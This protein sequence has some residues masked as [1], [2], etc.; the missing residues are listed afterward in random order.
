[1]LLGV[2]RAAFERDGYIHVE[3]LKGQIVEVGSTDESKRAEQWIQEGLRAMESYVQKCNS[4][5]PTANEDRSE[6]L[7]YILVKNGQLFAKWKYSPLFK[8]FVLSSNRGNTCSYTII[9]HHLMSVNYTA[10][11]EAP[12]FPAHLTLH[13]N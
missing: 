11:T 9:H 3:D 2:M 7:R 1:M 8:E 12:D 10:F 5:W 4:V 6:L 13:D